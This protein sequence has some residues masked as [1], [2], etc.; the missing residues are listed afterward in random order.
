MYSAYAPE[1]LYAP[2][3]LT[4]LQSYTPGLVVEGRRSGRGDRDEEEGEKRRGR[5]EGEKGRG[6][7]KG[8]EGKAASVNIWLIFK[9]ERE[10]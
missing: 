6:Q 8:T 9:E 5:R 10:E 7:G 1:H 3:L 2:E 4:V